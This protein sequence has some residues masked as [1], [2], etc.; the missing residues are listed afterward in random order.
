MWMSGGTRLVEWID[1]QAPMLRRD[2]CDLIRVY[3][4][5]LLYGWGNDFLTGMVAKQQ[6]LKTGVTDKCC[7]AHLNSQTLNKGIED[8]EG[9]TLS[10]QEYCARAEQGMMS[11]MRLD[12]E[13]WEVFQSFRHNAANYS[14]E[15]F[16]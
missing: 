9:K 11:Y 13:R 4:S 2:I 5:D 6:N 7:I 14:Y 10:S 1:F 3:P 15:V 16:K 8:L 12:P